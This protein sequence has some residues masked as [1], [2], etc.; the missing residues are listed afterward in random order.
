MTQHHAYIALAVLCL[1]CAGNFED[2][3][4]DTREQSLTT[5]TVTLQ[6][7]TS[8]QYLCAEN[9]GGGAVNANRAAARSWETFRIL[10]RN[11]GAL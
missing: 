5:T 3:P 8:G 11:D 9:G 10:D 6:T 7:Q 2:E 4:L 1:G